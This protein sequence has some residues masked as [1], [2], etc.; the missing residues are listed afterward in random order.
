[1][2]SRLTRSLKLK[3]NYPLEQI[4]KAVKILQLL[5]YFQ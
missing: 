1:M 5:K 2:A 4:C 3:N